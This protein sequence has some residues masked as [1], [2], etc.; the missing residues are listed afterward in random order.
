MC[1]GTCCVCRNVI[2]NLKRLQ[3]NGNVLFIELFSRIVNS[4]FGGKKRIRND[5]GALIY[6]IRLKLACGIFATV[7]DFKQ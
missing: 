6:L 4:N 7:F 5:E 3:Y 1:I 2:S